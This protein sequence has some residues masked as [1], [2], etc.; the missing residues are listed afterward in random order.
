MSKIIKTVGLIIIVFAAGGGAWYA[1]SNKGETKQSLRSKAV[2]LQDQAAKAAASAA[3]NQTT[4][5]TSQSIALGSETVSRS[6]NPTVLGQATPQTATTPKV[7][8]FSAFQS[9][10]DK[11]VAAFSDTKTGTGKEVSAGNTV[12]VLYVGRLTSGT[13]FDQSRP[14]ADGKI[15]PFSFTVGAG[16][17]IQGWE[18]AIVGMKLGGVRRIVVPPAVGYGATGVGNVIPPNAVLIFDVELLTIQ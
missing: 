5:Q 10:A 16:Q 2:M 8:D 9:Y 7:E 17:V 12:S 15:A 1:A 3:T 11:Q 4:S 13:I 14:N 18:Q 6:V